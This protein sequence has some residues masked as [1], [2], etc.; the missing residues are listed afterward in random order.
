MLGAS[1]TPSRGRERSG[2]SAATLA[3]SSN[4]GIGQSDIAL[5]ASAFGPLVNRSSSPRPSSTSNNNNGNDRRGQQYQQQQYQPARP[6][7]SHSSHYVYG[8]KSFS[9]FGG[10]LS[11]PA[12]A[13]GGADEQGGMLTPPSFF[14]SRNPDVFKPPSHQQQQ[15]QQQRPASRLAGYQPQSLFEA[16]LPSPAP[17]TTAASATSSSSDMPNF[18]SHSFVTTPA[19]RAQSRMSTNTNNAQAMSFFDNPAQNMTF[20]GNG[21]RRSA[22]EDA[23][24]LARFK[25]QRLVW[26]PDEDAGY[27]RGTVIGDHPST[28][29]VTVQLK[30]RDGYRYSNHVDGST[31]V[32]DV[33]DTQDVNPPKFDGRDD[34]AELA[35]LNEASV[36]Y[37]LDLRFRNNNIYTFSGLFL[38]SINPYR[39]L[40]IYGDD[41]IQLYKS[42]HSGSNKHV[43]PPH[44][45]SITDRAYHAML[46]NYDDQSILVTG[47]TSAGKTETTKKVIQYLVSIASSLDGKN[48][49]HALERQILRTNPIL[50]AFGN[51]KTKRNNNSSRFGKFIRIL[52]GGESGQIAGANIDW[53]LLEK[54]RV[55]H[56]NVHDNEERN[57]H[58]F[59]Q[60]LKGAP[61]AI[62][63][64]LQLKVESGPS[65]YR[66]TRNTP[67][68]VDGINDEDDF[69]SVQEAMEVMSFTGP[70][71]LD[72]LRVVA[73]VLH[74]G[75]I[76]IQSSNTSANS[77]FTNSQSI[78]EN[79]SA[80]ISDYDSV[81]RACHVLGVSTN[82]FIRALL[83]PRMKA[84][85]EWV[86]RGQSVAQAT[87]AVES[88][89]RTLYER[90]FGRLVSRIN[91]SIDSAAGVVSFIG[92][93]DIA[94]FEIY[95]SK[96]TFEQLL[97]NYTNE[98]LQQFFNHH[99]FV[100]EQQEYKRE[101]INWNDVDFGLDLQP[102]IDLIEKNNPV[103]ILACLDDECM[104]PKATDSKFT[105]KLHS[106]W[107]GKSNVY[108]ADR[109]GMGFV[110]KHYASN[111][112]YYTTTV[113]I[114]TITLLISLILNLSLSLMLARYQTSLVLAVI[115][116]IIT[117]TR[118]MAMEVAQCIHAEVHS[119]Q[120]FNVTKNSWPR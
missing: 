70:Q 118:L 53:Y 24:E 12:T 117:N 40:P 57:Y 23:V 9:N 59:Y 15:Q 31:R 103:G 13:H 93:L 100:L 113:T 11:R 46:R 86:V 10:D 25:S 39:E 30:G 49:Y 61:S 55:T 79:A 26:I 74:L 47:Q 95:D 71:Q 56:P 111:V 90:M 51:A 38:V 64:V 112:T 62:K 32:I 85:R 18:F 106:L 22:A 36:M 107:R 58:V 120:W 96:N 27:L 109:F 99:M 84:G 2:S 105:E 1:S 110:I 91:E 43:L 65:D 68:I 5:R 35:Y 16:R 116:L 21:Q 82:D 44:I 4:A 3:G 108:E 17:T 63:D 102:T 115:V 81:N 41:V 98:K 72:F 7:T 80:H 101:D 19:P 6:G 50:E 78:D 92:V 119:A 67:I 97:I 60:L 87:Y 45:Y 37:N 83:S 28:G 29:Q 89:A 48:D 94:G 76:N 33:S 66:F 54:S 69:R 20:V 88:L 75:N 73:A 8:G 77:F 34:V 42:N 104:L 114:S 52:F 14:T